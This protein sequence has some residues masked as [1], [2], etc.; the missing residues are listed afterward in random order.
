MF[1]LDTNVL[2]VLMTAQPSPE[3][4]A[5]MSAQPPDL[6]FTAAICQAEILAGL[7]I[8][9]EDRR[10]FELE[11][12]ARAMF[13]EDFE[14]RLLAFDSAAAENYARHIRSP[15]ASRAAGSNDR[16]DDCRRCPQPWGQCRHAQRQQLRG[17]R[18]GHRQSV[19]RMNRR[20]SSGSRGPSAY[21]GY[22]PAAAVQTQYNL[23]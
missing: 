18:C 13:L 3:V 2:S 4:G 8:L 20:S 23:V 15:S 19:D 17:L 7:A 11:T 6:L 1:L 21:A 5:W 10:R 16:P 12:A 9:P 14:G 22:R